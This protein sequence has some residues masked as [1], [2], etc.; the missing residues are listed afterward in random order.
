MG[1]PSRGVGSLWCAKRTRGWEVPNS[2]A[3]VRRV[4][5]VAWERYVGEIGRESPPTFLPPDL[6]FAGEPV[7]SAQSQKKSKTKL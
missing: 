4:V 7:V 5:G 6:T 1:V 2:G 3:V